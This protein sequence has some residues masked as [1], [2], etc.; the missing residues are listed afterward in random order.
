MNEFFEILKSNPII[1]NINDLKN[2]DRALE[3][4]AHIIFLSAGTIFNLKEISKQI[5]DKKKLLYINVDTIEGFSKDLLGLEYIIK[6]IRLSGIISSK[7]V[8][9]RK[10]IEFQVFTIFKVFISDYQSLNKTITLTNKNRPHCL[11]V[12][13]GSLPKILNSLSTL[14]IPV[15]SGGL[16]DTYDEADKCIKLGAIGITSENKNLWD[17]RSFY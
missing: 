7:E 8:I 1:A 5:F 16:I 15:I 9:I 13:P 17:L 12:Y 3:S 4:K 11:E 2:L 14:N 6:N 10:S